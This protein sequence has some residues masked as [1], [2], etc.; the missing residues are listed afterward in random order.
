MTTLAKDPIDT[1]AEQRSVSAEFCPQCGAGVRDGDRFC[2][3]CGVPSAG[4]AAKANTQ[5]LPL[6]GPPAPSVPERVKRLKRP[7]TFGG[8]LT[9]LL[10]TAVLFA[11][12]G[13]AMVLTDTGPRGPQGAQGQQGP[14]GPQGDRG[15]RGRIGKTGP[16]GLNG[17][18][19][20]V[21]TPGRPGATKACS[22]DLDVPLPYC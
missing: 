4:S 12:V 1:A 16:A 2:W 9:A 20:A 19:G 13:A 17:A 8:L 11:S 7:V 5:A 22:N 18:A 14:V 21:G 15:V 6:A 3:G 10:V